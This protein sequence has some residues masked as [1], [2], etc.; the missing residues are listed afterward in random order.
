MSQYQ[1][2]RR[3]F[4]LGEV[5]IDAQSKDLLENWH[6]GLAVQLK[7][8]CNAQLKAQQ[9]QI[10]ETEQ[11]VYGVWDEQ[12]IESLL[13]VSPYKER[14][15]KQFNMLGSGISERDQQEIE[16]VFFDGVTTD[17]LTKEQ[18]AIPDLWMKTSWL[19]FYEQDASLRFRFSFGVD[20]EQDVAADPKRQKFAAELCDKVFPES[21]ILSKH[22]ELSSLL[23]TLLKQDHVNFVERIIYFNA[24]QGGA[25]LH[26]DLE[27]GHAG[28]VYA[29]LSGQTFWL[30]LPR[31][32][33]IDSI[34]TYSKQHTLAKSTQELCSA[35]DKLGAE[36]D[37]FAN[38]DLITLINETPD[39]IQFLHQSGYSR[40]MQSGDV[41]LLPQSSS[42][43]CCWHS[44]FSLGDEV[45]Q[46]LSFAI[47]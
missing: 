42:Q 40:L 21:A 30:A 34:I 1:L 29:Q 10:L 35:P 16:T 44:V 18:T 15:E 14:L 33:L 25:Y 6:Q 8:F 2:Q 12:A 7:G 20:L 9:Q 26:H 5:T 45:G 41:L 32:Q 31:A 19:S 37:S 43:Q 13:C 23:T 27:R 4:D 46:A 3:G 28:V 38:D 17:D 24:P 36:L 11:L 39:F 47:R 22:R